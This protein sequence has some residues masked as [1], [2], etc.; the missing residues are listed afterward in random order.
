MQYGEGSV[1]RR[2]RLPLP[3]RLLAASRDAHQAGLHE[4]AC[5]ALAAAAYAAEDLGDFDALAEILADARAQIAWLDAHVPEHRASTRGSR[6]LGQPDIYDRL[7][8]HLERCLAPGGND[9]PGQPAHPA[10]PAR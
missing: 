5:Y 8:H 6:R 9:G 1:D 10:P 7:V 4:A 3:Q 2:R